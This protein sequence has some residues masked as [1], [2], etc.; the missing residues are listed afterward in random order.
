MRRHALLAAMRGQVEVDRDAVDQ[1]VQAADQPLRIVGARMR[2]RVAMADQLAGQ[3]DLGAVRRQQPAPAPAGNVLV[4]HAPENPAVSLVEYLVADLP[5]CHD[6]RRRSERICLRQLD[7]EQPA[8]VPQRGEDDRAAFPILR[9]H[10]P[11][12]ELHHQQ[13]ADGAAPD[14]PLRVV[15]GGRGSDDADEVPPPADERPV[16]VDRDHWML[17]LAGAPLAP[18]VR[19]GSGLQLPHLQDRGSE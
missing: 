18:Q 3:V 14:T 6:H 12:H 10:Q 13:G 1:A 4:P 9:A 11:E 15:F 8:V 2:G 16:G 7:A 17:A 19:P 5:A